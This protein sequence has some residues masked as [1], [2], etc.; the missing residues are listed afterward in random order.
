M[1]SLMFLH[2]RHTPDD[3]DIW[4]EAIRRGWN[5]ARVNQIDVKD[6]MEGFDFVRYYGNTLH[7]AQIE[8]QLPF[9]FVPIDYSILAKISDYYTSRHIHYMRFADLKQPVQ[10]D[11]FIKPARDKFFEAKVYLRGSMIEGTP[12]G[13]DMVYV[14]DVVRFMDEVR[15]FVLDGEIQTAS[16]YRID[17]ISYR[18]VDMP[19]E[20]INFDD[21]LKDTIIPKWT[22]EICSKFKLPRGVVIDFGRFHDGG[23][24]V[25]EFNEAW[26]SGLY[27]CRPDKCFD[28]IVASQT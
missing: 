13:D 24:A 11:L 15:C 2:N 25:I 7:G 22:K 21:Q 17:G 23:W 27:Y 4:K 10:E 3:Q 18:E 5:T 14:S 6:K 20:E 26:A 28:V 12:Q 1:K 9:K 8:N 16:L 19:P